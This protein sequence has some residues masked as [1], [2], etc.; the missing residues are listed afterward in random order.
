MDSLARCHGGPGAVLNTNREAY[1]EGTFFQVADQAADFNTIDAEH[2]ST[3]K[4]RDRL[5]SLNNHTGL[6]R[7]DCTLHGRR[8]T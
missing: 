3:M 1:L 4:Q 8:I 6:M 2:V 7:W 5:F